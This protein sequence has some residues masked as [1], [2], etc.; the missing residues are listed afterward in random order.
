MIHFIVIHG[1][2][3]FDKVVGYLVRYYATIPY[4]D[5]LARLDYIRTLS[6]GSCKVTWFQVNSYPRFYSIHFILK[7]ADYKHIRKHCSFVEDSY[8]IQALSE[9]GGKD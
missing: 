8:N 2:H 6:I 5:K 9:A 3:Y 4:G 1:V 7:L